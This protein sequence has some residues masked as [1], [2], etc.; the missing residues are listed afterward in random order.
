[1][2]T[3]VLSR[4]IFYIYIYPGFHH[5][6]GPSFTTKKKRTDRFRFFFFSLFLCFFFSMPFSFSLNV[7]YFLFLLLVMYSIY[8]SFIITSLL[9][10][11][12]TD[13]DPQRS[14]V[15]CII[16][17]NKTLFVCCT[18]YSRQIIMYTFFFTGK[19]CLVQ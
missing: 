12:C 11:L 19:N 18:I 5:N 14:T 3:Y 1:M 16:K 4:Y 6:L 15:F 7:G 10:Q 8:V 2:F 9:L 17:K 13:Q